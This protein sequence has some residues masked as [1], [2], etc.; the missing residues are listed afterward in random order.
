MIQMRLAKIILVFS[1]G[2]Y[3]FFVVLGNVMD[4]NSNFQFVKHVLS[5]DTT[6]PEN[7]LMWRSITNPIL[8]HAFYVLII[9]SEAAVTYFCFTG[10]IDLFK[11]LKTSPEEFNNAKKKSITGLTLAFILWFAGFI[12]IGGE[13]FL[14]WQSEIWNGIEPAFRISVIALLIILVVSRED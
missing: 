9:C 14:M 6:F 10:G 8:H 3:A 11:K 13:W 12:I 5:M 1:L 2:L 4:Y 7:S